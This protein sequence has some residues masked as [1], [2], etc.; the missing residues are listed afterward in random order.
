M[1]G[2]TA[3]PM[4]NAITMQL[5]AS[6]F[7]PALPRSQALKSPAKRARSTPGAT[8]PAAANTG[9]NLALDLSDE[10]DDGGETLDMGT[11][12]NVYSHYGGQLGGCLQKTGEGQANIG[13]IIDG[14]SG[15]V[16]WVKVNG[17]QGG[18]LYGCLSS[19]LRGM[20]FPAIHGPRTRAEFDIAL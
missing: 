11:V 14:P 9:E 6:Y 4:P 16:T 2:T 17:K 1:I 10:S 12:Y 7:S 18:G 19:V 20:K 3:S 15:R 8:G 13:I 5:R